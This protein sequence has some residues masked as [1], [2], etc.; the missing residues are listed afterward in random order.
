MNIE[1]ATQAVFATPELILLVSKHLTTPDLARCNLVCKDWSR[2]FEP[3]LW[4]TFYLRFDDASLMNYT[5]TL[6][7]R[8]A[9]IRNLPHIRALDL[10]SVDDT[11]LQLL[12]GR[13]VPLFDD[14]NLG[15]S[16][17]FLNLRRL[18]LGL[19]KHDRLA[20][21][22]LCLATLLTRSQLLTHLDL[23]HEFLESSAVLAAVSGLRRLQHLTVHSAAGTSTRCRN[24][25]LLLKACLHLPELTGL[26]FID[27]ELNWDEVDQSEEEDV[28]EAETII[29]EASI[30]RFSQCPTATKI[31]SLRLPSSRKG[32]RNPLPLLLLK[33]YL[34][35]LESC[36][37]P[38][39]R[40]DAD[41]QE[42]EQV[43]RKHCPNLKH[44]LCPIFRG[45][46]QR[47][48]ETVRAFIRG[49][50]GLRSFSSK[51]F[52][53]SDVDSFDAFY[54][55]HTFYDIS[56]RLIIPEVVQHHCNTLEVFDLTDCIQV[57]SVDQQNV[58]SRCRQ[59]KRFWVTNSTRDGGIVGIECQDICMND[60][61]CSELRELSLVLNLHPRKEHAIDSLKMMLEGYE[62]FKWGDWDDPVDL[63]VL[64]AVAA[65]RVYAQIGGLAKLE[66]LA[67]DIDRSF[68]N[69]AT[70]DELDFEYNLTWSCGSLRRLEGLKNL[71]SLE[72]KVDFWS[73]MGQVEVEFIYTNWPLLSEIT[74]CGDISQLR[75]LPHWQWLLNKRPQLRLKGSE[76]LHI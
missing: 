66:V 12:L 15:P 23:P 74:I 17:L 2:Q 27:T 4:T 76:E 1:S 3:I 11:F 40:Y 42:I 13:L 20:P 9:L 69:M 49:C 75:A 38:W 28:P 46:R 41:I 32:T 14:T 26:F 57:F 19:I 22:S 73:A 52:T 67:L 54:F 72:L 65:D 16:I 24:T 6:P 50:S 21:T 29:S 35:D 59:L 30:A 36:E 10:V 18:K 61:V 48:S 55:D 33:S 25:L 53:D 58:L 47:N 45:G 8:L 5:P 70:D 43:V 56:Q 7:L 60:W 71:R 31:T 62:G 51:Y 39:I 44:L 63:D 34:L 68:E 64:L 37:I